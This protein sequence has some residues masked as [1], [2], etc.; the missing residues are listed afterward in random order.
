MHQQPLGFLH[1]GSFS[2]SSTKGYFVYASDVNKACAYS[3]LREL[4]ICLPALRCFVRTPGPKRAEGCR[5]RQISLS[6]RKASESKTN[7]TYSKLHR[8]FQ[9]SFVVSCSPLVYLSTF[10]HSS[11]YLGR[12]AQ[13][14]KDDVSLK[15]SDNL[16]LTFASLTMLHLFPPLSSVSQL[17]Q[18]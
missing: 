5:E 9:I 14:I 10:V 17:S 16:K 7:Q 8:L 4:C 15:T 1:L 2:Q 3:S 18:N 12:R 6:N 11:Y 13:E